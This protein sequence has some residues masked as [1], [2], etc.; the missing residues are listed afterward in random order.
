MIDDVNCFSWSRDWRRQGSERR[1]SCDGG[2]S[3]MGRFSTERRRRR[4]K[5][6]LL[7]RRMKQ[8]VNIEFGNQGWNDDLLLVLLANIQHHLW[9]M[10]QFVMVFP[11][12]LCQRKVCFWL[13]IVSSSSCLN[14]VI[15]SVPVLLQQQ[16][17]C[18]ERGKN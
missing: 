7:A 12:D 15:C 11:T 9:F 4:R 1:W 13:K 6:L 10:I 8:S 16:K 17:C 14:C 2:R 18:L 3:L 5:R